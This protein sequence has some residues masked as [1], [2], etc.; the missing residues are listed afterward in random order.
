MLDGHD[1]LA[2]SAWARKI[3]G[4][5]RLLIDEVRCYLELRHINRQWV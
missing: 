2:G 3:G 5:P 1:R 4:S